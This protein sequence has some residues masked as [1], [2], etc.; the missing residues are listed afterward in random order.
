M[1]GLDPEFTVTGVPPLRGVRTRL[2][3][4]T[5]QVGEPGG[6]KLRVTPVALAEEP[7]LVGGK[8]T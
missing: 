3:W 1:M 5:G 2:Y 6:V 8:A 4:V 7:R